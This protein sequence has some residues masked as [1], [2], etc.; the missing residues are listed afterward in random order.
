MSKCACCGKPVVTPGRLLKLGLDPH[1][2][3]MRDL[4]RMRPRCVFLV[5]FHPDAE[6]RLDLLERG[7]PTTTGFHAIDDED[8]LEKL[9]GHF[10]TPWLLDGW[11]GPK[12]YLVGGDNALVLINLDPVRV[13]S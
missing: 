2:P 5:V 1:I 4:S 7:L 8:V 6:A 10:S 9:E 13:S 11:P 3:K 12:A